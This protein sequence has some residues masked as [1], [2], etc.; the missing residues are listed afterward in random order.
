MAL[1]SI[2]GC[3]LSSATGTYLAKFTNGL[4]R[5]ELVQSGD[6]MLTGEVDW[7]SFD[8]NGRLTSSSAS[9]TGMMDGGAVNLT[10]KGNAFLSGTSTGAGELGWNGITLTGNFNGGKV[11]TVTFARANELEYQW[12]LVAV[13]K[14]AQAIAFARE[15]AERQRQEDAKRNQRVARIEKLTAILKNFDTEASVHLHRW[16]GAEKTMQAITSDM[17]AKLQQ[18]H[19]LEGNGV[20]RGQLAVAIN[21]DDVSAE[22]MHN[23]LLSLKN[24]FTNNVEPMMAIAGRA[25]SICASDSRPD[26]ASAC[27]AFSQA[28]ATALPQYQAVSTGLDHLE[29]I[30]Q[31]EH[32]KHQ[33]IMQ[34]ATAAN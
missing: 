24:D 21:Q 8:T 17:E 30:Y 28:Y 6:H 16:P 31:I 15:Q 26:V 22:Q 2:Y 13:E 32:Q 4:A 7:V 27:Q 3:S 23:Q 12:T 18:E 19:S 9:V 14:N 25:K 1:L 29:S 10:F 34:A 5:L 11:S 33:D 20:A